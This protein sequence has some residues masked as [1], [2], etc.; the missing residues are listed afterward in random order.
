MIAGG[1]DEV[2]DEAG[3]ADLM[4]AISFLHGLGDTGSMN[5]NTSWIDQ[6]WLGF[7]T[8][9]TGTNPLSDRLVTAALVL[10]GLN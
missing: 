3:F 9:T 5:E 8:E 2:I 7:D 10:R 6:P 4:I 1:C